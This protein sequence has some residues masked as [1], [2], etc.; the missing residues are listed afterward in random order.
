MS[1]LRKTEHVLGHVEGSP[2][3]GYVYFSRQ[4]DEA[5]DLPLDVHLPRE[6]WDDMGRPEVVTVTVQPGD[7]L[8][9]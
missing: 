5:G 1:T 8:N 3:E 2:L 9:R 7:R 4:P 6:D